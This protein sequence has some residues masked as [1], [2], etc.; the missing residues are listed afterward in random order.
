[1]T[2]S[3]YEM[4]IAV[5]TAVRVCI[6]LMFVKVVNGQTAV[7]WLE[8]RSPFDLEVSSIPIRG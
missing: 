4:S 6:F 3:L 5:W 1:M 7:S 2:D 8:T